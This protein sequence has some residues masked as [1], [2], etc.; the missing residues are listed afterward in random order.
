[1]I[2]SCSLCTAHVAAEQKRINDRAAYERSLDE[3]F[4]AVSAQRAAEGKSALAKSLWLS[5]CY[6][7]EEYRLMKA[8]GV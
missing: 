2:C 3:Q 1:M 8:I 5:G 4:V 6:D 7:E